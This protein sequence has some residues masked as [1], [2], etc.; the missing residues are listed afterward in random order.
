[1][2]PCLTRLKESFERLNNW[3]FTLNVKDVTDSLQ[4]QMTRPVQ[5][6]QGKRYF[7]IGHHAAGGVGCVG[8]ESQDLRLGV[9]R[10]VPDDG[11]ALVGFGWMGQAHSMALTLPPLGAV[12]FTPDRECEHGA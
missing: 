1:M 3:L 10:Q 11:V 4:A 2:L 5:Q 12:V 7:S 9:G 8:E 6:G